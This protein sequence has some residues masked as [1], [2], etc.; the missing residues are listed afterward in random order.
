MNKPAVSIVVPVFNSCEIAPELFRRV[1]S[2]LANIEFELILVNDGSSD[3]S[4]EIISALSKQNPQVVAIDLRA[5][6]GQDNAILAGLRQVTGDYVVIMDDDL[7]HDPADIPSMIEKCATGFDVVFADFRVWK[8]SVARKAGSRLNGGFA[9]WLLGKPRGLYLSPFKI[10]NGS[11]A[12]EV[13]RFNGPYPY[14][15]GIILALCP[16]IAQVIVSHHERYSGRSNYTLQ[17]STS[18]WFRLFTGFSIA[19]LRI[20]TI[21]GLLIALIG[22]GL[23]GKYLYEYFFTTHIVEG[24]TTMVILQIFFGGLILLILGLIGEYM[25]RIYVAI[26]GKP[27]YSIRAIS[28][29]GEQ[30]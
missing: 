11:F 18:L 27:Q 21:T 3:H 17:K 12:K 20:A 29:Y 7:Q 24:W 4:W 8:Q 16:R 25:G 19:P 13:A 14:I 30:K 2:C 9:R 15:D 1:C 6:Y 23:I 22:L 26:N 5:N 28:R 10:M